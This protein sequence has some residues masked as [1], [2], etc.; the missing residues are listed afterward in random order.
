MIGSISFTTIASIY[1]GPS[2][3]RIDIATS[4]TIDRPEKT[5]LSIL[6]FSQPI[7]VGIPN[8]CLSF[9]NATKLAD[10]LYELRC[11][12]SSSIY[13]DC[14]Q[15]ENKSYLDKVGDGNSLQQIGTGQSVQFLAQRANGKQAVSSLA[16]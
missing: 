13:R 2:R 1:R 14:V 6:A 10:A 4:R 8:G 7:T 9:I 3:I 16:L 11:K 15:H 12:V 5:D